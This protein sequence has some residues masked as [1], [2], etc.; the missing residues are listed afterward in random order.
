[1]MQPVAVVQQPPS[2]APQASRPR[3]LLVTS[4]VD[5]GA[6]IAGAARLMWRH[7]PV[8][9]VIY[10]AG[11]AA[12]QWLMELATKASRINGELGLLVFLTGTLILLACFV[13]MLA[14]AV[15]SLHAGHR[16]RTSDLLRQLTSLIIPFVAIYAA[17]G[18]LASD[19]SGYYY[20]LWFTDPFGDQGNKLPFD[21]RTAS[22]VV[23]AV[24]VVLRWT[25]PRWRNSKAWLLVVVVSGYVEIL[26]VA[27]VARWITPVTSSTNPDGP[28]LGDRLFVAWLSTGWA[29][30]ADALGPLHG[31]AVWVGQQ[32][33]NADVALLAP[34]GWLLLG[35]VIY[36]GDAVV[37]QD[38]PE[39]SP[40]PRWLAAMPGPVRWL[41][42]G[43]RS[44][45][46]TRFSP[47]ADGI[48]VMFRA[49][50]IPV[51]VLCLL[52]TAFMADSWWLWEIE[53]FLIGP[54]DL[55]SRWA[56]LSYWL[57]PLNDAIAV[58]GITCVVAATVGRLRLRRIEL[59][60][61][62]DEPVTQAQ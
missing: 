1:M 14:V 53:R 54:R 25:V 48:R 57:V 11:L 23:F 55:W 22:I 28:V 51:I 30:F 46:S 15:S 2:V 34:V 19:F 27:G 10:F 8:L 42:S 40:P 3:S 39:E 7:W 12:K 62:K 49:R 59:L 24:V 61:E 21:S 31:A 17:L 45:L 37:P 29:R 60:P 56:P 52:V 16:P 20:Q 44:D 36:R 6:I 18:L 32:V 58:V 5:G 50:V 26:W 9:L 35:L 4:L 47:L 13:L 41:G 38:R 43:V 33:G